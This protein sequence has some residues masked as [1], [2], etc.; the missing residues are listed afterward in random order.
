MFFCGTRNALFL[1]GSVNE[2]GRL[3]MSLENIENTY[4]SVAEYNRQQDE[5]EYAD[6]DNNVPDFK[7]YYY[8]AIEKRIAVLEAQI[9][10]LTDISDNMR[11]SYDDALMADPYMPDDDKRNMDIDYDFYDKRITHLIDTAQKELGALINSLVYSSDINDRIYAA[12]N[13]FNLEVLVNDKSVDV[14]VAVAEMG[15]GHERLVN[16]ISATVRYTV[17][18]N[19]DDYNIF[20]QLVNDEDIPTRRVVL[21]SNSMEL[22]EVLAKD[23]HPFIRAEAEKKLKSYTLEAALTSDAYES[24]LYISKV[25]I[26]GDEISAYSDEYGDIPTFETL[27]ELENYAN[28]NNLDVKIS[29]NLYDICKDITSKNDLSKEVLDTVGFLHSS[30]KNYEMF[31]ANYSIGSNKYE[32]Y[33]IEAT[34]A[35]LKTGDITAPQKAIEEATKDNVPL[36]RGDKI[37]LSPTASFTGLC[38]EDVAFVDTPLNRR[39]L[40][41]YINDLIIAENGLDVKPLIELDR[42]EQ[43]RILERINGNNLIDRLDVAKMG[44]GLHK[45]IND[46][47][48]EIREQVANKGYG[49]GTLMNDPNPDVRATVALRGSDGIRFRLSFDNTD[50][51]KDMLKEVGYV[52]DV[53]KLRMVAEQQE[54]SSHLRL[55]DD[56]IPYPVLSFSHNLTHLDFQVAVLDPTEITYYD[57]ADGFDVDEGYTYDE[58][59]ICEH[60]I[61]DINTEASKYAYSSK[62]ISTA[63]RTLADAV[64]DA[65]YNEGLDTYL[66]KNKDN[67]DKS[68]SQT[69]NL[70]ERE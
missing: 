56:Q 31:N 30:N 68:Q 48:W 6:R 40:E 45:L 36:I 53:D 44:Y 33:A 59:D 41:I 46:P 49:L 9:K 52:S 25:N 35:F 37:Y 1:I 26:E 43:D 61:D 19:T 38:R 27:S 69:K 57:P 5:K 18:K 10:E 3:T 8:E 29:G 60:I 55:P 67:Q 65:Y 4:G 58:E 28:T 15:Y 34:D 2:K 54:W 70:K 22:L 17:G 14:R 12:H 66:N 21:N 7:N 39:A 64:Y 51:V 32:I 63:I 20:K 11:V 16:D 47:D 13:G 50:E 42:Q 24:P 62:D 23:N